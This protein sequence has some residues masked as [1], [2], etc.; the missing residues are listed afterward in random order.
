MPLA[1]MMFVLYG[2]YAAWVYLRFFQP[3]GDGI[4][5]DQHNEAFAFIHFFPVCLRPVL[6]LATTL[7]FRLM[8]HMPCLSGAQEQKRSV[9]KVMAVKSLPGH[10]QKQA[11]GYRCALSYSNALVHTPRISRGRCGGG[12]RTRAMDLLDAKL[13][14]AMKARESGGD[15]EGGGGGLVG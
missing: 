11:A 10:S 7:C 13:Q 14:A 4:M 1:K 8:E 2:S 12:H 3:K 6:L 9:E 5:G 15:V